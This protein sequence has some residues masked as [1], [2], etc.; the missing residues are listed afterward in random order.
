MGGE[1]FLIACRTQSEGRAID[2]ALYKS[3][4]SGRNE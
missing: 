1:E 3:K 4:S 2:S